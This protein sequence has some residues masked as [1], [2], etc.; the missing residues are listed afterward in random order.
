MGRLSGKSP[1]SDLEEYCK[2]LGIN[3]RKVVRLPYKSD[4]YSC[5]MVSVS[6][7]D[8]QTLLNAD[9]WPEGVKI[10]KFYKHRSVNNTST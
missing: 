2:S 4:W 5:F 9:L 8:R 1:P 3:T 10:R 7:S 6:E